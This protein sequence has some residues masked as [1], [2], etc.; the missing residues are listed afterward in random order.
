MFHKTSIHQ[1]S[2]K[3]QRNIEQKAPI[4]ML[5]NCRQEQSTPNDF[6]TP[7][8]PVRESMR[9]A[10]RPDVTSKQFDNFNTNHPSIYEAAPTTPVHNNQ[11]ILALNQLCEPPT[12]DA[13]R[14]EPPRAER[15]HD[16]LAG[17]SIISAQSLPGLPSSSQHHQPCSSTK[18]WGSGPSGHIG[19][20]EATWWVSAT[21]YCGS[22]A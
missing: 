5:M 20:Y 22:Q 10:E 9:F 6:S 21:R 14:T 15:A 8:M 7:T 3:I 19:W 4:T 1:Q 2:M 18:T 11:R 16:S 13:T 12:T 17:E